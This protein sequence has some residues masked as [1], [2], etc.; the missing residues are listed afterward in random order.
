MIPC[1]CWE[2]RHLEISL[3]GDNSGQEWVIWTYVF[4]RAQMTKFTNSQQL[5]WVYKHEEH[6]GTGNQ[7]FYLLFLGLNYLGYSQVGFHLAHPGS[8]WVAL[9][10]LC[11]LKLT[12]SRVLQFTYSHKTSCKDTDK[13]LPEIMN[14]NTYPLHRHLVLLRGLGYSLHHLCPYFLRHLRNRR[15]FRAVLL[16]SF[17]WCVAFSVLAPLVCGVQARSAFSWGEVSLQRSF[18]LFLM[19]VCSR[20]RRFTRAFVHKWGFLL[21]SFFNTRQTNKTKNARHVPSSS[22]SGVSPFSGT[23]S[24]MLDGAVGMLSSVCCCFLLGFHCASVLRFF[25]MKDFPRPMSTVA[26]FGF[27][28]VFDV[29]LFSCLFCVPGI[30]FLCFES[31]HDFTWKCNKLTWSVQAPTHFERWKSS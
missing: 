2:G 20:H 26:F 8:F 29:C 7:T 12:R 30:I 25:L 17:A 19:H 16:W 13:K 5:D 24:E 27:G 6:E 21:A 4:T 11:P 22:L 31:V 1:W 14:R 9:V 10:L 3:S 28:V 18:L 23:G 15:K